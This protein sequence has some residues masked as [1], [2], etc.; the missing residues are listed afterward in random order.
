ML[1]LPVNQQQ[2]PLPTGSVSVP[3]MPFL[4]SDAVYGH[5]HIHLHASPASLYSAAAPQ[6]PHAQMLDSFSTPSSSTP[7]SLPAI[8][9]WHQQGHAH[10]HPPQQPSS[11]ASNPAASASTPKQSLI[12]DPLTASKVHMVE[13][14]VDTAA[15]IIES[16]WPSPAGA[17]YSSKAPVI[18]LHIFVKETLRRSRTTLSTLQLAL[19][20]IYKVRSQVLAAQEKIRQDQIQILHQHQQLQHQQHLL[21][22]KHAQHPL[23]PLSPDDSVEA[24]SEEEFKQR[25]YFNSL[26]PKRNTLPLTPPG[27]NNTPSAS[28]LSPHSLSAQTAP[29]PILAKSEPVGCGRRMFLAALILAS[30]FQQDRTYSNKAWSKISGL[31]V[32]EINQNE[33]AF[34]N[35]IDYQLFVSPVTFQKWVLILTERGSRRARPSLVRSNSL[36]CAGGN[37]CSSDQVSAK[38]LKRY[39]SEIMK[40]AACD[41][42]R[43]RLSTWVMILTE[44]GSKLRDRS[45]P[46]PSLPVRANSAYF[47]SPSSTSETAS[48]P[49]LPVRRNSIQ[50]CNYTLPS[51]MT[52]VTASSLEHEQPQ[53]LAQPQPMQKHQQQ[54]QQQSLVSA[55]HQLAAMQPPPHL[56]PFALLMNESLPQL[57]QL[58]PMATGPL[59]FDFGASSLPKLTAENIKASG[60]LQPENQPRQQ[61][62][63]GAYLTHRW[64]QAQRREFLRVRMKALGFAV[65]DSPRTSMLSSPPS[66]TSAEPYPAVQQQQPAQQETEKIFNNYRNNIITYS[67]NGSYS[68]NMRRP[69]PALP[70]IKVNTMTGAQTMAD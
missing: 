34:L 8:R 44:K 5:S 59:S 33:I 42:Q 6:Q 20:Y 46:L 49:P 70:V 16:I 1:C 14:L 7:S 28:S 47:A 35:L 65:G 69:A 68:L 37:S 39:S 40:D 3:P 31:P 43:Y 67:S 22:L 19:Y 9:S 64:V 23:Q 45:P 18:P 13:N 4:A 55:M 21:A 63:M 17:Q 58:Q 52:C 66:A 10:T 15:L 25:D 60:L 30:K 11:A 61:Q 48:H 38:R 41:A 57:Q 53:P 2:Q 27:I 54:Q 36:P 50:Y 12:L 32:P 62:G 56:P 51:R 26:A 29:S 24:L